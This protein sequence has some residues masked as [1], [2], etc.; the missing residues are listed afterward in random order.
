MRQASVR[1]ADQAIARTEPLTCT[2][3]DDPPALLDQTLNRR[4]VN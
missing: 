3:L 1:I 2:T 4:S